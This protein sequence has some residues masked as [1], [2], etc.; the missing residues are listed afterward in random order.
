MTEINV[1][2]LAEEAHMEEILIQFESHI[3]KHCGLSFVI[4]L[5]LRFIS[6]TV[7]SCIFVGSLNSLKRIR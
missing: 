5:P 7:W 2:G 1:C 3:S 6:R 4:W